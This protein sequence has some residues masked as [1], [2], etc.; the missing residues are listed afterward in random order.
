M[1]DWNCQN[2]DGNTPVMECMML[3]QYWESIE[4]SNII[5]RIGLNVVNNYGETLLSI[6]LHTHRFN[7]VK[8][9]VSRG[10]G[11]SLQPHFELKIKDGALEP[12]PINA[13]SQTCYLCNPNSI[14]CD[15][16]NIM[17]NC[18]KTTAEIRRKNIVICLR[19]THLFQNILPLVLSRMVETYLIPNIA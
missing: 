12:S 13:E 15:N 16:H 4:V 14:S 3:G 17:I 7:V 5:D 8:H 6:A 11:V 19:D 1:V 2:S 9:L 18:V 10:Y